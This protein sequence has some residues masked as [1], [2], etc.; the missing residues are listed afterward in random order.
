MMRGKRWPVV[1]GVAVGLVVIVAG[2]V[3]LLSRHPAPASVPAP[4]TP[5]VG[6]VTVAAPT[7]N[8]AS[9]SASPS[10]TGVPTGVLKTGYPE[11][12]ELGDAPV[13]LPVW[14]TIPALN[15]KKAAVIQ[16]GLSAGNYPS[17]MD[18]PAGSLD[19]APLDNVPQEAGWYK[20]GTRPGE[21]GPAIIA[22]HINYNGTEGVFADLPEMRPGELIYVGLADGTMVTFQVTRKTTT[23][24]A[25]FPTSDVYG[26]TADPEL[27]LVGCSGDYVVNG[28]Y[29]DNTIVYATEVT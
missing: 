28:H 7:A 21:I 1:L 29:P 9:P 27:R 26:P 16:L 17:A 18:L 12:T 6:K 8:T 14:L 20:D 5:S 19:T 25:H 11:P 3:G 10:P 15:V 23:P 2:T 4:A 13:A 24:K 22:G